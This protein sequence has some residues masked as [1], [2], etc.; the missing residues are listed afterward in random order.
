MPVSG[1]LGGGGGSWCPVSPSDMAGQIDN[2]L[3]RI[4][5]LEQDMAEL[6]AQNTEA[7]QLSDLSA[8][9]GWIYDVVYM[10]V[11]GWTQTP[12]GTLI[13]PANGS[14]TVSQILADAQQRDQLSYSG[15]SGEMSN[16]L[17]CQAATTVLNSNRP[18]ISTIKYSHGTAFGTSD[19][20][21]GKITINEDGYYYISISLPAGFDNTP[22][23]WIYMQVSIVDPVFSTLQRQDGHGVDVFDQNVSNTYRLSFGFE[24]HATAVVQV[25]FF[26]ITQLTQINY[27]TVTIEKLRNNL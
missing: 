23:S 5:Q 11:P 12:A 19:L 15:I 18:D 22:T 21:I 13:P 10:G 8:S 6:K 25:S 3:S 20:D 9:A 4:E 26:G 16:Y 17:V 27:S 7:I 1:D 2:L 24:A 14:F